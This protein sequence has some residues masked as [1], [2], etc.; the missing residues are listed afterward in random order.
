V[1]DNAK[2]II[3][4]EKLL[5]SL[6]EAAEKQHGAAAADDHQAL[7]VA[8]L[9]AAEA[10]R[11]SDAE[12]LFNLAIKANPKSASEL[13]LVWGV[14]L[15][16]DNKPAEA[17]A[18]FQRA[19]DEKV[20]PDE[21]PA[22]YFYLAGALEMQGKTDEALAAAKIAAEKQPKNPEM[23]G[24]PAWILYHAK[25]YDDAAKAY[26]ELIQKFE[27]DY[28]TD[29]VRETLHQAREALSNICVQKNDNKQAVEWLEQVLDEFPDDPGANN[30][31][32]YLWADQNQ[33]LNRAEKMTQLAVAA[34]PD[35]FAYRDSLGWA[36]FRLGRY[37]EALAQLQKAANTDE[38]D[39]E[40]LGHIAEV[41]AKLGQDAEAKAAW[42]R[43]AE[44]FKKAG[45]TEKMKVAEQKL[46]ARNSKHE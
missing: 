23:A 39:G 18:V 15:L 37:A 3:K 11:W 4:D 5:A 12:K 10:K 26:Q 7:R 34:E 22:M 20:L 2:E 27:D 16:V 19:I 9:L 45:E 21:N 38:P 17:A 1:E 40:V 28:T 35:N 41:H 46:E 30:D 8:A 33:H 36:L 24:R 29:G 14:G 44:A 13:L 43:A 31:L 42:T 32:G 25:R 6:I